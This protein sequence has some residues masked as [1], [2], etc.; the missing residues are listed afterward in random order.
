VL[1]F[2]DGGGLLSFEQQDGFVHTL[3]TAEGLARK[4]ANLQIG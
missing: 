2:P 1:R 4:L 3:N